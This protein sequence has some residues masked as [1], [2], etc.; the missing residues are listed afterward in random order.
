MLDMGFIPDIEEI[1]TKLPK[2]SGRPCSSRRRCRRRSRSWPTSSSQSQDDRGRAAGDRQPA[3]STSGWSKVDPRKKRDALVAAAARRGGQ[4]RDR[5]LQP[6]DDG[7]RARHQ[8]EA[9]TASPSARSTA[10]WTSPTG[11]P[12]STASRTDEIN[13]LVAS[14]VAARGLDIKGVSHVFNLR[15]ALASGRLCPPHRPHRPRRRDRHRHHPG[16]RARTPRRSTIS[17]S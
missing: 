8:P 11:S 10:T 1:C 3:A 12:S 9:R 14:D 6:Q 5:L 4:E 13:I 17:R 7:A 15:R 2:P 16:R